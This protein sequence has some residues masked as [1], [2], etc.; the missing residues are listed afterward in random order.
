MMTRKRRY[1]ETIFQQYAVWIAITGVIAALGI[2]HVWLE[3]QTRNLTQ[4]IMNL[5]TQKRALSRE[6]AQLQVE[7]TRLSAYKAVQ[8]VV[9]ELLNL[10][11]PAIGQVITL[12]PQDTAAT[13]RTPFV[14]SMPEADA[15]TR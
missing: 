10:E 3:I 14:A 12:S 13:S 6:I 5:E 4:D 11:Y 7:V 2:F 1:P 15:I 8:P 9:L